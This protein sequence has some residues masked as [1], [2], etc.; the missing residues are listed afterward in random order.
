MLNKGQIFSGHSNEAATLQMWSSRHSFCLSSR[1]EVRG[2]RAARSVCVRPED[3]VSSLSISACSAVRAAV[4][5]RPTSSEPLPVSCSEG[6]RVHSAPNSP[7]KNNNKQQEQRRRESSERPSGSNLTAL[8]FRTRS[9]LLTAE[10]LLS[11]SFR[12]PL[13]SARNINSMCQMKP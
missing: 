2:Q 8:A 7:E 3:R 12:K 11:L 5:P 1:S 6:R 13:S 9:D 10:P 4:I